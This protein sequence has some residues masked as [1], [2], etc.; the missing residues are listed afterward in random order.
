MRRTCALLNKLSEHYRVTDGNEG[1]KVGLDKEGRL[2]L[3]L[4]LEE[5]EGGRY[6]KLSFEERNLDMPVDAVLREIVEAVD[7]A[8]PERQRRCGC[9]TCD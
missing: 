3:E 1:H 6:H 4:W 5:A 2:S 9:R 7:N 8:S